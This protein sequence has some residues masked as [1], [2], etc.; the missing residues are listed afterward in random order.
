M[1]GPGCP[2][3]VEIRLRRTVSQGSLGDTETIIVTMLRAA[4]PYH[5]VSGSLT[6]SHVV[7]PEGIVVAKVLAAVVDDRMGPGVADSIGD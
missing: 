6:H 4:I 3:H 1:S 2:G 7:T 5:G